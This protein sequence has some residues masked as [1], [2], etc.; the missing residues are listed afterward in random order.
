MN[1]QGNKKL[2]KYFFAIPRKKDIFK[3]ER[4]EEKYKI[5]PQ[6]DP[7]SLTYKLIQIVRNKEAIPPGL[8]EASEK[9]ISN[10]YNQLER[11]SDFFDQ[12]LA[13]LERLYSDPDIKNLK[14]GGLIEK[15]S[16][17]D[18]LFYALKGIKI[19]INP[20]PARKCQC[21]DK[22]FFVKQFSPKR[23]C[24]NKCKQKIKNEQ[25]NIKNNVESHEFCLICETSLVGKRAGT[26]TCS[27]ACRKQLSLIKYRR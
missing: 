26:K 5:D 16:R 3:W 12:Y 19:T 15:P 14:L 4:L 18:R 8:F 25:R 2:K 17:R 21:C 23:Y 9:E 24:S 27:P 20:E 11:D 1:I 7:D 10:F 22:F 6:S 13:K